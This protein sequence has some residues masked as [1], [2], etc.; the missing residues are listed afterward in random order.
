MEAWAAI[1]LLELYE[2]PTIP[3]TLKSS[4]CKIWQGHGYNFDNIYLRIGVYNFLGN[5]DVIQIIA[6]FKS[7][8][9]DELDSLQIKDASI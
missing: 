7:H 5:E 4:A 1:L 9:L 2:A 8:V 3:D 6:S